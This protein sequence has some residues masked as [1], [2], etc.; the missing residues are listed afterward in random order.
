MIGI[1]GTVLINRGRGRATLSATQSIHRIDSQLGRLLDINSAWRD[2]F[3]QEKLYN[4]Y[5]RDPKNNPIALAPEDSVHCKGEAIDSDDGYNASIVRVLNSNGWFHTVYRV[6]NGVRVLKEPW[7]F[8]YTYSKD[9]FRGGTPAGEADDSMSAQ[10]VA[11]LKTHMDQ[12][13]KNYLG[14]NGANYTVPQLIQQDTADIRNRIYVKD[15]QGNI[16]W[17]AFQDI[18]SRLAAIE[19]KIN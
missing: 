14:V 13:F 2:P 17:D 1:S 6:E 3:E 16:L 15:A 12:Q 9:N 7:H 11:A 10:D 8:E 19:A 18:R 5:Q 4:A